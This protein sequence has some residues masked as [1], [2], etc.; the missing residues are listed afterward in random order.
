MSAPPPLGDTTLRSP[1]DHREAQGQHTRALSD[2]WGLFSIGAL[3]WVGALSTCFLG[4]HW[5]DTGEFIG[6]SRSLSLA[7]PPGHPLTLLSAHIIQ[8]IPWFDV[9]VRGNLASAFWNAL[10]ALALYQSSWTLL[11]RESPF[12]RRL[13]SMLTAGLYV[14]LP[15]VWLQGVRAEVYAPQATL[16][17]GLWMGFILQEYTR[18]QRWWLFS[19]LCLGLLGANHTLLAVA[20]TPCVVGWLLWKRVSLYVWTWGGALA[21]CGLS[22][23][24]YLPLRGRAGG[25]LGWGWVDGF[26]PLW[27]TLSAKVWQTQVSQRVTEV[28]WG[29][30]LSRFG[31]F[32]INQVGILSGLIALS[33]SILA[34][35]KWMRRSSY[36]ADLDQ[37]DVRT[38]RALRRWALFFMIGA[39]SVAITKLTYPFSEINPDF[40]GYLASGASA[41]CL[42]LL[43]TSLHLGAR[44]AI[45][46]LSLC[47]VGALSQERIQGR[48][49]S[50]G[51]EEWGRALSE[52]TPPHGA[53]W[54]SYYGT[55]FI[56][57]GLLA[58]EG[59]RPD[60]ALIFRGHRQLS[61]AQ[62]RVALRAPLWAQQMGDLGFDHPK[63]RFEVE[64]ALDAHPQLTHRVR[65]IG[66]SFAVAPWFSVDLSPDELAERLDLIQVAS[67]AG[68]LS[69]S[70]SLRATDLDTA[71]SW[72][73]Y[74]ELSLMRLKM[75][76]RPSDQ[77]TSSVVPLSPLLN[78]P[79]LYK[80]HFDWKKEWI[81][82]ITERQWI[83]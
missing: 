28:N 39:I 70:S 33:V 1:Q 78:H 54:T 67:Y 52:E 46:C 6:A 53:L 3:A 5:Q 19:A 77:A 10:G 24:L 65:Q 35:L 9:S 31:A 41:A 14:A 58:S 64:G 2:P 55:H 66:F 69:D 25:V 44:G 76:Q 60:I 7:H 57:T 72:A 27:E 17:T 22:L 61:W 13:L 43:L 12:E 71:Y 75:V 8:L 40:S 82:R 49:E 81:H 79:H 56:L 63:A 29:E 21:C 80:A 34:L 42:Y 26:A 51:A 20:I 16:T 48:L 47:G 11:H 30:N 23:Y 18:D 32:C 62:K 4:I 50:R 59:L 74:H 38:Q 68:R 83:Y 73:L 36:E 37:E 15:L 45:I